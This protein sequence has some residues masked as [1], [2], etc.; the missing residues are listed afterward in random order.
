[1]KLVTR[2]M[3]NE[4]CEALWTEI[5]YQN[6]KNIPQADEAISVFQFT[7]LLRKR[8]EKL[9]KAWTRGSLDCIQQGRLQVL[10][11]LHE[12]RKIGATTIRAIALNGVVARD[13]NNK[14][15]G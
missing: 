1:M 9:E 6:N 12:L 11:T 4:V 2:E 10:A 13:P 15:K 14:K 7:E 3:F 5:A 8:V